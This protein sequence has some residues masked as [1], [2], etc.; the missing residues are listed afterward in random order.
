M[1]AAYSHAYPKLTCVRL[2]KYHRNDDPRNRSTVTKPFSSRGWGLGTRLNTVRACTCVSVRRS[3]STVFLD[4]RGSS[5]LQTVLRILRRETK[6][7]ERKIAGKRAGS[8][9]DSLA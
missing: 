8:Q 4:N 3:V 9:G 5:E 7:F 2:R 1:H 6:I